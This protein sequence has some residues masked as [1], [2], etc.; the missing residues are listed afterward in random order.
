MTFHRE[1][2]F[3]ISTIEKQVFLIAS[4]FD[5][6]LKTDSEIIKKLKEISF[7]GDVF[8]DML[9]KNGNISTRFLSVFFDGERFKTNRAR[10]L[11][12]KDNFLSIGNEFYKKNSHLIEN[13][14]LSRNEK[15]E[16]L[17]S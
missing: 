8:I 3:Y 12:D 1:G 6:S 2:N 15:W 7:Q 13:S 17:S 10:V 14:I 16:L 5:A 9:L 11:E 4:T